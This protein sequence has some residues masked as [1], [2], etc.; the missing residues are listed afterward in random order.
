MLPRTCFSL[1]DYLSF[2]VSNS[3][4]VQVII[5]KMEVDVEETN[6]IKCS[7][8]GYVNKYRKN[9]SKNIE[10]SECKFKTYFSNPR[11]N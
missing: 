11:L 10:C 2:N 5:D 1:F 3:T 6:L 4:N 9:I 7:Q 8:C